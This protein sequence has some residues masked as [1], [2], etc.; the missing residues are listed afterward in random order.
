MKTQ[1]FTRMGV[2]SK[3]SPP[4]CWKFSRCSKR[5]VSLQMDWKRGWKA[6]HYLW[7]NQHVYSERIMNVLHLIQ[8]IQEAVTLITPDNPTE[9][10]ARAVSF[11]RRVY[12][13]LTKLSSCRIISLE[14][15]KTSWIV[16]CEDCILFFTIYNMIKILCWSPTTTV[17][18]HTLDTRR[19]EEAPTT[20]KAKPTNYSIPIEKVVIGVISREFWSMK[21]YLLRNR[22]V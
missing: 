2:N 14:A 17:Y 10:L 21:Y 19:V 7:E 1:N 8:G 9:C 13:E 3:F 22:T 11:G 12:A 18:G 15:K 4:F 16:Q 5:K 6:W 20:V